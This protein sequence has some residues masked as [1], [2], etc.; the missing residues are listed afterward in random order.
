MRLALKRS[1][2]GASSVIEGAVET[3]LA[4]SR[5]A[6][7]DLSEARAD[8]AVV[9]RC[10]RRLDGDIGTHR[11]QVAVKT[12]VESEQTREREGCLGS[13]GSEA[14][15]DTVAALGMVHQDLELAAAVRAAVEGAL[16]RGRCGTDADSRAAP[17]RDP[18]ARRDFGAARGALR[19]NGVRRVR[20]KC[21]VLGA[22]SCLYVHRPCVELLYR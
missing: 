12:A 11:G 5:L 8:A 22:G 15:A 19:R 18:R 2:V 9:L 21:D 3:F 6:I 7:S 13:F 10:D 1:A 14:A 17:R 20:G 4:C 16:R